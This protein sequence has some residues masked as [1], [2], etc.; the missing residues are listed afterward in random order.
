M[1]VSFIECPEKTTDLW[2]VTDKLNHIMLYQVH[3]IWAGFKLTTLVVIGTD[4]IGSFKSNYHMITTTT[5][6]TIIGT[7]F[8]I[9][10]IIRYSS[11]S[12]TR[13]FAKC[14][15]SHND[16]HIKG[17][18]SSRVR[19]QVHWDSE[20]LLNCPYPSR[21]VTPLIRQLFIAERVAL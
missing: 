17:H 15:L 21:E 10:L 4:C 14:H 20:I 6:P 11:H 8:Y 12:L 7:C 9:F 13:P 16:T 19:F 2:Q 5:A 18:H 3:L 1:A